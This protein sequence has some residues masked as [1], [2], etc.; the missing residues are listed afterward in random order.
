MVPTDGSTLSAR[1][2][3]VAE[4]LARAQGAELVLVRIVDPPDAYDWGL[5]AYFTQDVHEE[6]VESL[7]LAA[8]QDLAVMAQEIGTRGVIAKPLAFFDKPAAGLLDAEANVQPDLLV[9]ASHGRSGVARFAL[10]SVAER[11]VREGSAPVLVVHAL[12]PVDQKMDLA[13]VPLDGSPLAELAL[14]MLESLA[15]KP[16]RQV[17]L[18]RAVGRPVDASEAREYLEEVRLRLQPAG[19]SVSIEVRVDDPVAAIR[20]AAECADLIVLATHGRGGF[21]RLRHGSVAEQVTR[22]SQ[23]R[24]LLIRAGIPQ[25]VTNLLPAVATGVA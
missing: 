1:A 17:R 11:L 16:V 8:E 4:E 24:V 15:G 19:L 21:D 13:L 6:L 22:T 18:M 7:K 3:P 2:V 20:D 23:T 14:P 10:G 9:M 25:S 12:S 5:E